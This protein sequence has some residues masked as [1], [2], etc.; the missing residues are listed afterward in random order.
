MAVVDA[1]YK[2]IT[3]DIG[4]FG[5]NSDGGTWKNSKFGKCFDN[6]KVNIPEPRNLPNS[7]IQAPY[8]LLGDEAFALRPNF[9]RPYPGKSLNNPR[10]IFNYRLSRAR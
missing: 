2:F 1:D 9:L 10:R 3:V 8:V 5:S 7:L 4:G 6:N